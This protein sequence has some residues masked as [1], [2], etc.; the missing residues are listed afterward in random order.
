MRPITLLLVVLLFSQLARVADARPRFKSSG[1]TYKLHSGSMYTRHAADHGRVL[2]AYSANPG[3]L[4]PDAIKHHAV[5][6]QQNVTAAT[7]ALIKAKPL[8]EDKES[9]DLVKALEGHYADCNEHCK[10]LMAGGMD[11]KAMT[12]CCSDLVKSLEA[13]Q[14]DH[15][16]LMKKLGVDPLES[17]AGSKKK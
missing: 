13:A 10:K 1:D 11:E 17:A 7:S 2:R 12:D 4:S 15:D 5:Q 6:V 14:G 16:K 9:Q 8:A 3:A